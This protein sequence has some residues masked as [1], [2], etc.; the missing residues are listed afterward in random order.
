VI[1]IRE[2]LAPDTLAVLNR[3]FRDLLSEGS[4]SQRKAFPEEAD[5]PE[6]ADLARIV[7]RFNSGSHGRLR[8]LIDRINGPPHD[9]R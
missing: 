8:Q 5:E 4:I 3:D 9:D 1:R 6:I 2:P 7:F